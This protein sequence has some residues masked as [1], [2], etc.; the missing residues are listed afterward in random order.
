[1]YNFR[2]GLIKYLLR[3]DYSVDVAAPFDTDYTAKIE[4]LGATFHS[5]EISAK[6]T[7]PVTDLILIRNITKLL[8]K[9]KPDIAFFYTI[10]PNIYGGYAA[11][12]CKIPFIA[13]TTGL[14]YTF[15]NENI[16]STIARKLYKISFKHAEKVLFLNNDDKKDFLKYKI[17]P[18]DKCLIL[19]G[20]GI[21]T[22]RFYLKALPKKPSFLLMARMLWDKGIGEFVEAARIVK[23]D[24]P[25]IEFNLLG[26]LN[27]ENPSAIS[28]EQIQEWEDEGVVK[29]LGVTSDVLPFLHNNLSVVLPS[30]REGIPISLL[31][32]ASTGR[33]VITTDVTGCREAVNDKQ[34]GFLCKVKNA[35]DLADK[36]RK[37]ILMTPE[38]RYEMGMQAR[39]KVE[40]E[41]DQQIIFDIYC[42]MLN[43]I[44]NSTN[45]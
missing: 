36:I 11:H 5:I 38:E 21:D 39:K 9:T 20:E 23:R 27:A 25:D 2:A 28:K 44:F 34:T 14:G 42:Q 33:I 16:V 30:Y 24:W 1:M 12:I 17:L 37:V 10:K 40:D 45:E 8:N 22:E 7:N 32:A 6:G 13:V 43:N 31:E 19:N 4:D 15:I 41:F 18:E 26:F 3:N 29:Y 35:E